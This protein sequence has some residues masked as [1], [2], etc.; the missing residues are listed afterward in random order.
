ME[1]LQYMLQKLVR[2]QT[3][4]FKPYYKWN[5]F[6]TKVKPA[7]FQSDELGCFKPYYKWNTFNT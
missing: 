3:L 5:T 4:S 6:N 2:L 1:Y 7:E